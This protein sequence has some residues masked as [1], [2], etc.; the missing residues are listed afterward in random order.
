[1]G[2]VE[3]PFVFTLAVDASEPIRPEYLTRRMRGLRRE[4]GFEAADFD[5]TLHSLRHWTQTT[6]SEGGF[7]PRQVAQRGGHSEQVMNRVYVH[8]TRQAEQEMTAYIGDLLTP[9]PS[10]RRDASTTEGLRHRKQDEDD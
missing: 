3:D 2:L 1:M 7:N 8:R 4:L 6:L 9:G 5:T 10:S